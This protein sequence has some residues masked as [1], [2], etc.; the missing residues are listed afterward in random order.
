MTDRPIIFSAPMVCEII[1]GRKTMTRRKMER[2]WSLVG[3]GDR[4]WVR[5]NWRV[6]SW[7]ED[8]HLWIKYPADGAVRHIE[9][10]D[11]DQMDDLCEAVCSELDAKGVEKDKDG[12]YSST[13]RLKTRPSIHLPRWASRLTLVL[14]AKKIERLQAISNEDAIAEGCGVNFDHPNPELTRE[15]FP[16][17]RFRD[18]WIKLNGADSWDD[19]PE[20]VALT[21]KAHEQNI[22]SMPREVAA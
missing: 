14:I 15:R 16:A 4:F 17:E 9:D 1:A 8:G 18:L 6:H 3:P 11:P 7:D 13:V 21:F 20:V 5:E 10:G 12:Y 2:R 22:Y 19:N